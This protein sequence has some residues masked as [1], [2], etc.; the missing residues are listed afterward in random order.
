[1]RGALLYL[2]TVR[3]WGQITRVTREAAGAENPPVGS[4]TVPLDFWRSLS[5]GGFMANTGFPDDTLVTMVIE[6]LHETN[7]P[8]QAA[9]VIKLGL[10][11]LLLNALSHGVRRGPLERDFI[12][13]FPG[14]SQQRAWQFHHRVRPEATDRALEIPALLTTLDSHRKALVFDFDVMVAGLGELAL[15]LDKSGSSQFQSFPLARA[16][17]LQ[18]QRHSNDETRATSSARKPRRPLLGS[19]S[20]LRP[21]G[22]LSERFQGPDSSHDPLR[23]TDFFRK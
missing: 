5:Q 10:L 19:L 23:P 12:A 13:P 4:L 17:W 8:E 1:M 2:Y 7:K 15:A 11:H 22:P 14:S 21:V 6:R 18:L 20:K 3:R 9:A 16:A